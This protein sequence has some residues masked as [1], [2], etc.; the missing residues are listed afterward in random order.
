[1][2]NEVYLGQSIGSGIDRSMDL[3]KSGLNRLHSM[4]RWMPFFPLDEDVIPYQSKKYD[5]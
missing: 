1:M 3:S 4:S 5:V 2:I